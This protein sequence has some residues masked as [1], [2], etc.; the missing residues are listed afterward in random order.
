MHE[1]LSASFSARRTTLT[2]LAYSSHGLQWLIYSYVYGA[3]CVRSY[4][5]APQSIIGQRCLIV[6]LLGSLA[7]G[8]TY[9]L[10]WP[11]TVSQT[12]LTATFVYL[13]VNLIHAPYCWS[14]GV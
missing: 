14:V 11:Y 5:H 13:C 3:A 8:Y 4:R 10:Q 9:G 7:L 12:P 6:P 2:I 1:S